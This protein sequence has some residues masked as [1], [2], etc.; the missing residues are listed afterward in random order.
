[1][2]KRLLAATFLTVSACAA[3]VLAAGLPPPSPVDRPVEEERLSFQTSGTWWPRVA[4]NGD[5]AMVYGIGPMM[6]QRMEEWRR[7]GY[8]IHVMT[9][10][11]WGNYQDYVHGSWNGTK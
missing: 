8:R 9:G 3:G 5:V 6:P 2:R 11:A 1:M 4:L 7:H 10:V